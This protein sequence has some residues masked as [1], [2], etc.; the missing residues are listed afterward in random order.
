MVDSHW[1]VKNHS[2]HHGY[3]GLELNGFDP[4]IENI[5]DFMFADHEKEM[6]NERLAEDLIRRLHST[7]REAPIVYTH[8]VDSIAN[9]TPAR[10][11]DIDKA[12]EFLVSE[13]EMALLNASG[14]EKRIARPGKFDLIYTNPQI[15]FSFSKGASLGIRP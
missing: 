9:E 4:H 15:T 10:L 3:G 7:S 13:K 12:M 2:I 1:S 5:P 14:K 11:S 8:L 6:M